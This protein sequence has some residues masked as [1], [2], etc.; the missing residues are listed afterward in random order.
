MKHL[1]SYTIPL[2]LAA[3][4]IMAAGCNKAEIPVP[5]AVTDLKAYPGLYRAKV[6]FSVP[7]DAVAT[8]VFHSSGKYV[9]TAVE[10]PSAVQSVIVENLTPGE[11][12]LRVVTLNAEGENSDPRGIKVQVYDDSYGK[13]LPNRDLIEQITLSPTSVEMYFGDANEGEIEMRIEY[14]ATDGSAKV[15]VV[16]P[17]QTIVR[18]DEI[19]LSEDYLYYT[20][21]KPTEDFIDEFHTP[22]INAR[23]AA[24]K[25]FDKGMWKTA[26]E[27]GAETIDDDASTAWTSEKG[28]GTS[29]TVDMQVEKI[30]NG[31]SIVQN[32]D[33]TTSTFATRYRFEYSNDNE[34][35]Q[36]AA[37]AK[38]K[39]NGYRQTLEF[40]EPVS[41]R[42]FRITF[43]E[44]YS[45]G[46]P[47]SIA[48]LDLHNELRTSGENGE[49]MP[50]IA[51]GKFPFAT[52]G[53]DRFPN[54]GAGRFQQ[55][56]QWIHDGAYITADTGTGSAQFCTWCAPVW[57]CSTIENGKVYQ[58]F[59]ML[60]GIYSFKLDVG[61]TTDEKGVDM[62]AV[63]AKGNKLPDIDA[64]T[65]P[66]VLGHD[67]I[68]AH[69]SSMF[70][71]PFT[72]KEAGQVS[73]GIV[74]NLYN[75]YDEGAGTGIW[76]DMYM[77]AFELEAQ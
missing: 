63:I 8:K 22:S 13:N 41:S 14:T 43:T 56:T 58:M 20:V 45:E 10:D 49:L 38:L 61:H 70:S 25:N 11:N 39:T 5:E 16:T 68:V 64:L 72:V 48:E 32:G 33:F 7:S 17:D 29:I 75:I 23:T 47:I 3:L 34:Q 19:N 6:E 31:F 59:D 40:A 77:N 21:Y 50:V 53:S 9:E 26:G 42:Y 35:W 30:Y 28:A 12:T 69:Q 2:A 18:I 36:T 44:T 51:N 73:I 55:V 66:E 24:M 37:E 65:S 62:Y 52:D 1:S 76:S 4:V 57:G 74:Y 60:P 46:L 15:L 54:V 27:G 67:D 71:V